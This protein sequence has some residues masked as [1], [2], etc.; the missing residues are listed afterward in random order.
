[1]TEPAKYNFPKAEKVQVFEQINTY[2]ENQYPPAHP[3]PGRS[4][5]AVIIVSDTSYPVLAVPWF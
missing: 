2:I 1:M 4:G 3:K 5:L